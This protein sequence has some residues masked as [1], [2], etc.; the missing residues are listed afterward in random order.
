[1]Y[2]LSARRNLKHSLLK[3][4]WHRV[5]A[6]IKICWH[7]HQCQS[8]DPLL[9]GCFPSDIPFKGTITWKVTA[10]GLPQEHPFPP[11]PLLSFAHESA[12]RGHGWIDPTSAS[13]G[14]AACRHHCCLGHL[15]WGAH[16][17]RMATLASAEKPTRSIPSAKSRHQNTTW[18]M[19]NAKPSEKLLIACLG[20]I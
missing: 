17:G 11:S 13:E 3:D 10:M 20:F 8:Q 4:H 14:S 5:V 18:H 1:M 15:A 9:Q 7:H 2:V 19:R 12:T 6:V 16:H